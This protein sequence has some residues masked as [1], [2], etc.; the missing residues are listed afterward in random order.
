MHPLEGSPYEGLFVKLLLALF[1]F[2]R[3]LHG[4]FINW[5]AT[6][7]SGGSP[8]AAASH[9]PQPPLSGHVPL[10]RSTPPPRR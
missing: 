5:Q 6:S 8:L 4:H 2:T 1:T 7:R 3:S 10:P 9:A